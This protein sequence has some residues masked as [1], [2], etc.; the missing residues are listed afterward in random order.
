MESLFRFF[1]IKGL[2][3]FIF[4][5]CA[6]K[7]YF[8]PEHID[9]KRAFDGE[10]PSKIVDA[11]KYG[12]T[13]KNRKVLTEDNLDFSL[14]KDESFVGYSAENYIASKHCNTVLIY[15]QDTLRASFELPS[16]PLSATI[17]GE[18][19]AIVGNDNTIYLYDISSQKELFSKKSNAVTTVNSTIQAPI[20]F[21]GYIF[22]P[23][24]DGSVLV[25]SEKTFEVER[26]IIIDSAPFFNN[27]IYLKLQKD[28]LIAATSKR[29]LSI[30]QGKTYTYEDEVKD[31]QV[32]KSKIYISTLDGQIKELD[33][34]LNL[35]RKLKFQ[36]ASLPLL[37]I[38]QDKIYSIEDG[39][40]FL[41]EVDLKT[42]APLV[43]ELKLSR[44]ENIFSQKSRIYY[45]DRFLEF[46]K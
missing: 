20:F 24:L 9:G 5:G 12:A 44:G 4:F 11:S 30:D 27:V 29:V 46:S 6:S 16:C 39:S 15:K 2:F 18:K 42:F 21:D 25:V 1:L 38:I 10:L 3:F 14:Q 8:K 45:K 41:I 23:M 35:Q 28:L 34:M 32:Y 37:K 40:G 43:Y 13:L 33:S 19:I 7:E 36:F 22:Y 31:I 17:K 26:S